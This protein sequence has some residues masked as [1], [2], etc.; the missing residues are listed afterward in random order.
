ML[1]IGFRLAD[2]DFEF[3]SRAFHRYPVFYRQPIVPV[4]PGFF[5]RPGPDR[6]E[7]KVLE[8]RYRM[9]GGNDGAYRDEPRVTITYDEMGFRNPP[10]LRDWDVVVVGDSF[11]EL[12]F[13][14]YEDLFTTR[15]GALLNLRV[16]NL[17]VSYTGTFTQAYY[18]KEWGK[19]PRTREAV[20]A[21]FEGNDLIDALGER[22]RME[23]ASHDVSTTT[24]GTPAPSRLETLPS[25]SSLIKALYR[26]V[27]GWAPSASRRAP[28]VP[29]PNA[30]FV[31]GKARTPLD[32]DYYLP[33]ARALPEEV[34][35]SVR[36]AIGTWAATARA[37]GL[38]PW[39]VFLPCKRRV[40][41][42]YL[43]TSTGEPLPLMQSDIPEFIEG[44]ATAAG[45]RFVDVTPALRRATAAG[46]LTYNTR[47]DSHLN[48][49]GSL[50]VATALAEALGPEVGAPPP[51]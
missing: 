40:L 38:R 24:P 28:G 7:G 22:R 3:K 37:L 15:L 34:R 29:P 30:Y 6:W 45:M 2:F 5:R 44:L 42:G 4:G 46:R 33:D 21:F 31:S 20:L 50:V 14:P 26:L 48:R 11:T 19:S 8:T 16:K 25:Q 18:L 27:T 10:G 51:R 36:D 1:E 17:G 13:L 41:D 35:S 12:G 23:Q 39:L 43:V 32:T 9:I 47:A 49:D